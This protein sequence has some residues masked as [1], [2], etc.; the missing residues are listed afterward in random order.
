MCGGGGGGGGNGYNPM[1]AVIQ[2]ILKDLSIIAYALRAGGSLLAA[3]QPHHKSPPNLQI[4]LWK[5]LCPEFQKKQHT[6]TH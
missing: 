4:H 5:L 1:T 3:K 2:F 6:L